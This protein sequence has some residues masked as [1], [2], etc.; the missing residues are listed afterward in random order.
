MLLLC[1]HGMARG[2]TSDYSYFYWFDNDAST[3]RSYQSSATS[4]QQMADADGLSEAMHTVHVVVSDGEGRMS[5]PITRYFMKYSDIVPETKVYY[6]FDNESMPRL[7]SQGES[8]FLVDASALSD[9][10][11]LFHSIIFIS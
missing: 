7:A 3:L 8:A 4:W 6:W 1:W 2:Q 5:Q 9:G 11:H 10:F